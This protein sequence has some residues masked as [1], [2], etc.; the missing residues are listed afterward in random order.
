MDEFAQIAAQ[1]SDSTRTALIQPAPPPITERLIPA[2][3]KPEPFPPMPRM[4][5][6]E[7]L[8]SAVAGL[9]KEMAAFL[10]NH[11]PALDPTRFRQPLQ[12]FDWRVATGADRSD[13]VKVLHG[14]GLWESVRIPHYGP[15]VGKA[16]TLYRSSFQAASELFNHPSQWLRFGAV[17]YIAEVFLNG[18]YVGSHEGMFAPFEFDVSQILRKGTN[19]LVVKVTNDA[20]HRGYQVDGELVLGEKIYAATGPGWDDPELGWHHCPPGMGVYQGVSLEGRP[21]TFIEDLFVRPGRD[22]KSAELWID[23]HHGETRPVKLELFL[24]LFGRNFESRVFEN[25]PVKG[26]SEAGPGMNTYRTSFEISE[27]RLWTP[28]HPWLYQ[29]QVELGTVDGSVPDR[30]ERQWGMRTFSQD[31][32]TEPKGRFALN[33]NPIRLCGA[34]T[35]GFEQQDVANGD[36]DQLVDDILLAKVGNMNFLRITQRPVEPEVYDYCDRLGLMIQTDLPLFGAIRRNKVAECIRQTEEMERLVRGHPCCILVSFINEPFPDANGAGHRLLYRHE[37]ED[38]FASAAS[39]VRRLNP[40]RVVKPADG[41]YDPPAPGLPDNHIYNTWYNGHGLE[42]GKLHKGYW[43]E[44]KPGWCY[45]CGEFGAEGLDPG[46]LMWRRYPGEWMPETA[47]DPWDPRRI[48]KAQSHRFHFCFYDTPRTLPE[49]VRESQRHQAW[50]ARLQTEAFRRNADV[51]S[52]AI[53]LFIDAWPSGWMKAIVDCERRAKPAFFTYRHALEPLHISLRGD[54]DKL[55]AGDRGS[56]EIW[57]ANDSSRL[58]PD[59]KIRFQ[60]EDAGGSPLETGRQSIRINPH[61]VGYHASVALPTPA[62]EKRQRFR[63]RAQLADDTGTALTE[64]TFDYEVYPAVSAPATNPVSILGKPAGGAGRLADALGIGIVDWETLPPEGVLLIDDFERFES[65]RRELL[66]RV[67]A[68]LRIVVLEPQPGTYDLPGGP[69][70][71]EECGMNPRLFASRNTGHPLVAGFAADDFKWWF[72]P[73]TDCVTPHVP[74]TFPIHDGWKPILTTG[75]GA[76]R[77]DWRTSCVDAEYKLGKGSVIL[78]CLDLTARV[79][80]VPPARLYALRLCGLD[81][82]S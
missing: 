30:A 4:E 28:D 63:V 16:V 80:H 43:H 11:A 23:V 61:S 21:S 20:P 56:V 25:R 51:V 9:R 49:W 17:D 3:G 46:D 68:G 50:G 70:V 19:V 59:A 67:V 66:E 41:D 14:E 33:G 76:F 78:S 58:P 53:H 45:A 52:F 69:I 36:F 6:Q 8:E 39:A 65:L 13:F 37:M 72:D 42:L 24:S 40:D 57:I 44:V 47:D 26:L 38:F 71:V 34:N 77:D 81:E 27:P 29:I 79:S 48:V 7:Q 22:L 54:R 32:A 2:S 15:P 75:Q 1:K 60:I 5:T 73:G 12:E 55:F 10:E 62:A 35:M 64:N 31:L 82:E 74:N 18:N